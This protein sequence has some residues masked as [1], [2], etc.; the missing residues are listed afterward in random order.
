MG[1]FIERILQYLFLKNKNKIFVYILF[2]CKGQS[3]NISVV[4][5]RPVEMGWYRVFRKTSGRYVALENM[6]D[7]KEDWKL[8]GSVNLAELYPGMVL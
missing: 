5:E 3:Q 2:N 4:F 6:T 7:A 8:I 1:F